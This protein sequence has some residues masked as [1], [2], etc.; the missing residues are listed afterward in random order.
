MRIKLKELFYYTF[1]IFM[2][3]AKGIGLD[4]GDKLYY[5]LSIIAFVCV[6]CK[7]C[8]TKYSLREIT[9]IGAL[10]LI[11][12]LAYVNSGRLGI[13]LSILAIV[14]VKD[15]KIS[16][17]FRLGFL[18]YGICFTGTV[19]AAANGMIA[20]PMVVHEKGGIGEIIRWG[21]G[22][23]T[24][25]VFHISY[26]ILVVFI[27]YNLHEK[28]SLKHLSYLFVGNLL[29]FAFS[30]SY[31]GV[32]VTV[33]YLL[34]SCYAVKRKKLNRA[35]RIFCQLPLPLCVLFSIVMPFFAAT[36]IGRRLD[37]MLQ[38]RLSFSYYY[39]TSQPITLLGTRMKDVPN[40]WVIMDNGYVF[41]LMTYG[42]MVFLL[43]YIG[44]TVIIARYSKREGANGELAIIFSFLLYGIMEQFISNAFMN[45]SLL[46][47]GEALFSGIAGRETEGIK[48]FRIDR[49]GIKLG[50]WTWTAGIAGG[51]LF[52][53]YFIIIEKK[54]EHITVPVTALNYV[55][56]QSVVLHLEE[57]FEKKDDL[58]AVMNQYQ[59]K[60]T[61]TQFL[62][63][64]LRK[65][66][67][68][69]GNKEL[70]SQ[71][72][73]MTAEE[74]TGMLECSLPQYIH[75]DRVYNAF[76]VRLL[77][78]EPD[79]TGEVY[80]AV[81]EE[82]VKLMQAE[83]PEVH[84]EAVNAEVVGKSFGTD[85]IE[86]MTNKEIYMIQ[87]K[88]NILR[89]ENIRTGVVRMVT[90]VCIGILVSGIISVLSAKRSRSAQC[91]D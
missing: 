23:S 50:K 1:F 39:L 57:P 72:K 26:F 7:L 76:R 38:A 32:T 10:G 25:N 58:K 90:G 85:R 30:L 43:F 46:F 54:P 84:P 75:S 65:T 5:V 34:L 66:A 89:I 20:N 88:G 41:I 53:S 79:I 71:M 17:V 67:E 83:M 28:Y 19:L 9:V 68:E 21:M 86:H 45:V 73:N 70:I 47:M 81:L 87:K 59:E 18:V 78:G 15:I 44:Y 77:E 42:I 6:V 16:R 14:G 56:T 2:I 49:R 62:D 3:A 37:A 60:I 40:F 61:D 22:Y 31:T 74:I 13:V 27:V 80:G 4:S 63:I 36:G 91:G 52:L 51:I 35:E 55:N 48:A 12:V 29:V 33:F 8:I 11:A 82:I 24:G 69:P 64:V